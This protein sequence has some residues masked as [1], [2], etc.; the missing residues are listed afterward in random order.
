MKQLPASW[1]L[2]DQIKQRFGQ[3]TSGKQRAMVA[4]GH[5]LLVLHKVP[6]IQQTS[7]EAVFF[8]RKPDGN[9]EYSGGGRG[10]QPLVKHIQAYNTAEETFSQAYEQAQTAEDYF[11]ILEGMSALRISTKNL[12]TTLQSARDGI[13]EDR[14]IISLRDLA[15]DID[16][17]LDLLYENTKN[18][19]DY[20]I[21]RRAEDQTKLGLASVEAGHRLN[22]LAAIFFPLTA[23]SCVFGMN[24]TSGLEESAVITFWSVTFF[25]VMLGL[26]VRRWVI[27]GKWF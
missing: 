7:R 2:P 3:K 22:I 16:R 21:A 11:H 20:Y 23:V 15:Y 14:D 13:P 17:T 8:W 26:F 6:Q 25:A 27:T 4:E 24:V 18:A 9:W 10:L 12:Y 5:L 19:L 1:K